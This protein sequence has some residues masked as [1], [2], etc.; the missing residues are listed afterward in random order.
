MA[1]SRVD[2]LLVE[3]GLI[4]TREKARAAVL[5]GLVF[6]GD[7]PLT[8]PG[9]LVTATADVRLVQRPRYVSRGGEKLEHALRAFNVPVNGA[10]AVDIDASTGGF[11]DCLLQHG[12]AH[13]YAVD[14]GYGQFD[15]E[16]RRDSRVTLLERTN[17]RYLSS[18]PELVD[19]AVIDVSFI[20]LTKIL[21]P[22]R[23]LL[24]PDARVV[25]LVKPQ[26]EAERTEIARGGVVR[27]RNAHARVLGRVVAWTAT[28]GYRLLGLT[29]SPL[30]GPAG[31]VEFFIDLRLS[32][33]S[34]PAPRDGEA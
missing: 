13:V 7:R 4:E 25:A 19:L 2:V 27:D 30:R 6:S 22:L 16:L 9:L 31:N 3:R 29:R 10:V 12:A 5:A 8:K 20:S 18:L 1:K 23:A 14:V 32:Q 15:Y 24:K 28:H 33:P 17:A 26:F 34:S 21:E 11:T